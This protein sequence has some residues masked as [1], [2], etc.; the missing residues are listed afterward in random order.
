MKAYYRPNGTLVIK[1]DGEYDYIL[2]P[3]GRA[4]VVDLNGL[5]EGTRKLRLRKPSY[6]H[7]VP[8]KDVLL[9]RAAGPTGTAKIGRAHV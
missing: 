9:I 8:V 7:E 6:T 5:T 3:K 2:V 4:I 1:A